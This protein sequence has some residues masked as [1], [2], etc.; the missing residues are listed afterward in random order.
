MARWLEAALFFAA[1]SWD[2]RSNPRVTI[3]VFFTL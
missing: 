2:A 1:G 3:T